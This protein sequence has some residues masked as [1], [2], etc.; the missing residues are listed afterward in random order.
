MPTPSIDREVANVSHIASVYRALASTN[1]AVLLAADEIDLYRRLCELMTVRQA[2]DA[3]AI[4]I[5]I[6]PDDSL[7]VMA[8][9]GMPLHNIYTVN[10]VDS[11][12]AGLARLACDKVQV[13]LGTFYSDNKSKQ[14]A[15]TS[16][17][18]FAV[19]LPLLHERRVIGALLLQ[20]GVSTIF[21][22]AMLR[23]LEILTRTVTN[24][25]D[26]F[27]AADTQ[28]ENERVMVRLRNMFAALS[29]T[30]EA[31]LR[32]SAPEE[33]YQ[34]V[35]DAAVN[36]GK[37]TTTMILKPNLDTGWFETQA[38][39][40][41]G[42]DMMRNYRM[43]IDASIPEGQGTAGTAFRSRRASLRNN[44]VSDPRMTPWRPS[45]IHRLSPDA[46]SDHFH[47]RSF[48]YIPY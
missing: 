14:Q 26:Q 4:Y 25:L 15:A 2:F 3:A 21:D 42:E 46:T 27:S 36:S 32:T 48:H 19:A 17:D 40:S 47:Y 31:I 13:T 45:R 41:T 5:T 33:L 35:C 29:A 8:M 16:T 1:E 12:V 34:R 28:K 23:S 30:N 44:M 43:S 7:S 6:E 9:A 38:M 39:T 18:V 22:T 20:S 10:N 37:F 24:K 11:D